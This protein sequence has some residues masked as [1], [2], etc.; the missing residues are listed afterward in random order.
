MV[1]KI[2]AVN[3]VMEKRLRAE[4]VIFSTKDIAKYRRR[5]DSTCRPFQEYDVSQTGHC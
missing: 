3:E 1:Y 4:A 5:K 2:G